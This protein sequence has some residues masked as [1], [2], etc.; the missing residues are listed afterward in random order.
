M[1][2]HAK[3]RLEGNQLIVD[4]LSYPADAPVPT[5]ATYIRAN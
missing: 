3:F 5:T 1:F 4:Y 2:N